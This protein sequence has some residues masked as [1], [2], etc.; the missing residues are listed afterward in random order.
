[1]T[2]SDKAWQE[3]VSLVQ[4]DAD[5]KLKKMAARAALASAGLKGPAVRLVPLL[6]LDAVTVG[7]DGEVTGLDT[8]VNLLK[9]EYPGL[10]GEVKANGAPPAPGAINIG[11]RTAPPAKPKTS[12]QILA[13]QIT[14]GKS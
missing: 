7:D 2:D 8:Q 5:A 1:M 14:G 3:K 10:F 6:D 9:T 4:S 11:N 12:A 13:E